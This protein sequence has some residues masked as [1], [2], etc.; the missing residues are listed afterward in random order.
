MNNKTSLDVRN[1]T[2]WCEIS[3]F[4]QTFIIMNGNISDWTLKCVRTVLFINI[5]NSLHYISVSKIRVCDFYFCAKLRN[6][7][8]WTKI[9]WDD[10]LRCVIYFDI[11]LSTETA[12]P[13]SLAEDRLLRGENCTG[14]LNI[15]RNVVAVLRKEYQN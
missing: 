3:R 6:K 13:L 10:S 11:S 12:V 8:C 5:Y 9:F 14:Q 4:Y 15:Q 1:P 7:E 2:F